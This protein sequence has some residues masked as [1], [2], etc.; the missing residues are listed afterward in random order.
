MDPV[1]TGKSYTFASV[2]R[3]AYSEEEVGEFLEM[4]SETE[5]KPQVMYRT[6]QSE[7]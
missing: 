4:F 7:W 2:L 5:A 6:T 1:V 3:A